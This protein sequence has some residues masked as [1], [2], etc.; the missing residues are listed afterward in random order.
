M[1]NIKNKKTMAVLLTVGAITVTS[2]A[3]GIMSSFAD[4]NKKVKLS[5]KTD[6][7]TYPLKI[8]K[9]QDPICY[10]L[11]ENEEKQIAEYLEKMK[12]LT[13]AEK[14]QIIDTGNKVNPE[15]KKIEELEKQIDEIYASQDMSLLDQYEAIL[16]EHRELWDK[17]EE[18]PDSLTKEE[19]V[20]LEKEQEK[21]NQLEVQ[22]DKKAKELEVATADLNKQI[23]EIYARICEEQEKNREIWEKISENTMEEAIPYG[24][25]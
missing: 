2:I 24:Q 13:N 17:L 22:I 23:D 15:W 9:G 3:G 18:N 25:Y 7:I 16:E 20:I 5:R 21:L 8:G 10:P 14:K 1:K 19:R 11:R 12:F 4:E 6:A